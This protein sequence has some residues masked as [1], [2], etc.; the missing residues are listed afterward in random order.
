[1]SYIIVKKWGGEQTWRVLYCSN[2]RLG[3]N[4][5]YTTQCTVV[6]L[7]SSPM[8]GA[9]LHT[10]QPEVPAGSVLIACML[11]IERGQHKCL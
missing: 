9:T 8:L 7:A 11:G 2:K 10:L 5:H 3:P 6:I 1:M 4:L